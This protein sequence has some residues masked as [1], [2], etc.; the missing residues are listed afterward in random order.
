MFSLVVSVPFSPLDID[1]SRLAR[2]EWNALADRFRVWYIPKERGKDG[3]PMWY[4]MGR[5]VEHEEG[6]LVYGNI[7]VDCGGDKE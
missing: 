5:K 1:L 6:V 2:G 3:E 4:V 7:V